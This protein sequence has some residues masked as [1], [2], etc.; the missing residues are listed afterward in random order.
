[1]YLKQRNDLIKKLSEENIKINKNSVLYEALHTNLRLIEDYEISTMT[2]ST[3]GKPWY[4][5][6][7]NE[8]INFYFHLMNLYAYDLTEVNLDFRSEHSSLRSQEFFIFFERLENPFIKE[9]IGVSPI[10]KEELLLLA[11]EKKKFLSIWPTY[12]DSATKLKSSLETVTTK[13]ASI[14]NN[15]LTLINLPAK[16]NSL[17]VQIVPF[18]KLHGKQDTS[19]FIYLSKKDELSLDDYIFVIVHEF[20]HLTLSDFM[21]DYYFKYGYSEKLHL[22]EEVLI[23]FIYFESVKIKIASLSTCY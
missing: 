5:P 11:L 3:E 7:I 17:I 21:N 19:N 16:E 1:M 2:S 4:S 20:L 23:N 8:D 6:E 14:F 15:C 22:I 18:L 12:L 10:L 13:I 9:H